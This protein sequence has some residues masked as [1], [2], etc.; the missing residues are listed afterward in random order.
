MT[1]KFLF[2]A[3]AMFV[4]SS[5][6]TAEIYSWKDKFGNTVYGDHAPG[7]GAEK[8]KVPTAPVNTES[9]SNNGA[10]SSGQPSGSAAAERCT[11]ST[12]MLEDYEKSP[13]LFRKGEDG[14]QV[15]L[16]DE[17]KKKEIDIL[18]ASKEKACV[19]Q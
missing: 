16:T 10:G 3:L 5:S 14:G 2:A 11:K 1:N 7:E 18:R 17:E 15:I 4:L 19:K 8:V 12:T 13:Y 9:T 6:A